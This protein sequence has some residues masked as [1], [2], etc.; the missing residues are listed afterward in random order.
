MRLHK[1]IKLLDQ[2]ELALVLNLGL[3]ALM[4]DEGRR[5]QAEKKALKESRFSD[6]HAPSLIQAHMTSFSGGWT[7]GDARRDQNKLIDKLG[8]IV[9]LSTMSD[10]FSYRQFTP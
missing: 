3:N 7:E 8:A 5:I 1:L 4:E 2:Q 10:Q 9:E 6:A